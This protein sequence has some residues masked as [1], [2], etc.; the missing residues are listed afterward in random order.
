MNTPDPR[1][2]SEAEARLDYQ[3]ADYRVLQHGRYVRCA[4]TK[5]P[6]LLEDLKYWSAERQEAYAS[7]EAALKRHLDVT[8]RP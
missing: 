6:I 2:T 8:K 1:F 5:E 3:S 7:P 4:V